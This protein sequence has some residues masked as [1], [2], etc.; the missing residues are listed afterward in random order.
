M[1]VQDIR[2]DIFRLV[3]PCPCGLD[4]VLKE[5]YS[6]CC[7]A[8]KESLNLFGLQELLGEQLC[9]H[10]VCVRHPGFAQGGVVVYEPFPPF[11]GPEVER[12]FSFFRSSRIK[13]YEVNNMAFDVLRRYRGV[14]RARFCLTPD[15]DSIPDDVLDNVKDNLIPVLES[16]L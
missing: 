15:G 6:G 13:L 12:S 5:R 2:S 4:D 8:F 1:C 9:L 14:N 3:T 10:L 16:S 11:C 7:H